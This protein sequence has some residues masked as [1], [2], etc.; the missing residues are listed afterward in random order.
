MQVAALQCA[1]AD[2]PTGEQLVQ[3]DDQNIAGVG[4]PVQ[5]IQQRLTRA[6]GCAVGGRALV[7]ESGGVQRFARHPDTQPGALGLQHRPQVV[8][9]PIIQR[10][11][12]DGKPRLLG[13]LADGQVK[14]FL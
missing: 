7:V 3:A 6:V 14:K 11:I 12:A 9:R 2:Q 5:P 13:A 8:H 4:I 1:T 10:D